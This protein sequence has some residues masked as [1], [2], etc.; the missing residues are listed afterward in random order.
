MHLIFLLYIQNQ[1]PDRFSPTISPPPAVRAARRVSTSIQNK[2]A[3]AILRCD[4]MH[5]WMDRWTD[6]RTDG[7][8]DGWMDGWMDGCMDGYMDG[9]IDGWMDG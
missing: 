5:G 4:A 6:G 1:F 7:R 3:F 2:P 9:Y 8:T